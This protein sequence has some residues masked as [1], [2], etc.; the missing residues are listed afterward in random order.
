MHGFYQSNLELNVFNLGVESQTDVTRI[1]E[2]VVKELGLNDV[3]FTYTGGKRGWKGDVPHFQFDISK[4]KTIGWQPRFTSDE[5]IIKAISDLIKN[6][7]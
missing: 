7:L 2:L 1:G 4:I 6:G 3:Q 5:A